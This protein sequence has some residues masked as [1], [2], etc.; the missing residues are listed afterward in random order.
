M[1]ENRIA[2]IVEAGGI[3]GWEYGNDNAYL[4]KRFDF[5]NLEEASRFI[6]RVGVFAEENDHHPEW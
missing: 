1:N 5:T 3:E 6:S 4:R 2:N